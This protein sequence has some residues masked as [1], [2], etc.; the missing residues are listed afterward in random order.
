MESKNYGIYI[1]P[2]VV[3]VECKLD[4]VI[5]SGSGEVPP[6]GSEGGEDGGEIGE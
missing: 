2:E 4:G 1:A 3:D 5:L 6:G